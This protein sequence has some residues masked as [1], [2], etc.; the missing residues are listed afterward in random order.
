MENGKTQTK[1]YQV[2][3]YFYHTNIQIFLKSLLAKLKIVF[4]HITYFF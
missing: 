3:N 4:V 1:V 2:V